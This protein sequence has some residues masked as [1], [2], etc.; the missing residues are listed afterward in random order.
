MF[1]ANRSRQ[2]RLPL[3]NKASPL[4]GA[5]LCGEIEER[6]HFEVR[7]DL[8]TDGVEAKIKAE[9]TTISECKKLIELHQEKINT[10]IISIWGDDSKQKF[11]I[12][13]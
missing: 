11:T 12:C 6:N 5:L 2:P 4:G 1:N 10:K 13:I 9:E 8:R 7:A 3:H